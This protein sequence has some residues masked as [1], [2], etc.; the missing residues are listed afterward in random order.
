MEDETFEGEEVKELRGRSVGKTIYIPEVMRLNDTGPELKP[1]R[2]KGSDSGSLQATVARR[3]MVYRF[4]SQKLGGVFFWG[5]GHGG[6]EKQ[7]RNNSKDQGHLP[8][9]QGQ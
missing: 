4:E 2:S 7:L 1:S 6:Q 8:H 5:G 9:L 3:V